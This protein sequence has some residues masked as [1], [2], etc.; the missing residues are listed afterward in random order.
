VQQSVGKIAA[1]TGEQNKSAT[2]PRTHHAGY[3][4]EE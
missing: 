2:E 3:R 4:T 1:R